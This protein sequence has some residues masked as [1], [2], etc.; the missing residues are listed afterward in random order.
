MFKPLINKIASSLHRRYKGQSRLEMVLEFAQVAFACL[1]IV[2][3]TIA[4]ANDFSSDKVGR[5][6]ILAGLPFLMSSLWLIFRQR[7]FS[8]TLNGLFVSIFF[9]LCA[10]AR[11][12][13]GCQNLIFLSAFSLMLSNSLKTRRDFYMLGSALSLSAVLASFGGV[14]L[15]SASLNVAFEGGY[16]YLGSYMGFSGVGGESAMLTML[17]GGISFSIAIICAKRFGIIF[18][19]LAL[20]IFALLWYALF[21]CGNFIAL[22]AG[23]LIVMLAPIMYCVRQRVRRFYILM[24]ALLCIGTI[25][26]ELF[27]CYMGAMLSDL[28]FSSAFVYSFDFSSLADTHFWGSCCLTNAKEQGAMLF[29]QKYG[30]GLLALCAIYIVAL[31]I[32]SLRAFLKMPVERWVDGTPRFIGEDRAR[33]FGISNR[34]LADFGFTP[35]ERIFLGTSLCASVAGICSLAFAR[36]VE[37]LDSPLFMVCVLIF[38]L[39]NSKANISFEKSWKFMKY[40]FCALML[41]S[42]FYMFSFFNYMAFIKSFKFAHTYLPPE[43][44]DNSK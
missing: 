19:I 31:I 25:A 28:S 3:Y 6:T 11:N 42:A 34:H 21:R 20:A 44:V 17:L 10:W 8:I 7:K 14:A 16:N 37:T 1:F 30:W 2:V 5:I 38:L 27:D 33:K 36:G 15:Y 29:A 43:Q 41:A 13:V 4:N 40:V 39:G 35:V 23:V 9:L 32:L 26:A 12:F 22:S 18:Q 24:F